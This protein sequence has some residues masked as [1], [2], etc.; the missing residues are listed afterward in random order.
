M[1]APDRESS[2]KEVLAELLGT[3][4]AWGVVL[5]VIKQKAKSIKN[6]AFN[7]PDAA[8]TMQAIEAHN[9]LRGLVEMLFVPHIG[10]GLAKIGGIE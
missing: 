3:S 4:V 10:S 8:T 5:D 7:S 2:D 9:Q 1:L 6:A